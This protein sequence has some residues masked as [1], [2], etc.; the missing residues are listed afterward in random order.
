METNVKILAGI[1][2]TIFVLVIVSAAWP[3]S[4]PYSGGAQNVVFSA[5][6]QSVTPPNSS[7]PTVF[8]L[9]SSNLASATN[10]TF[11]ASYTASS[12]SNITIL[13][14]TNSGST[15]TQFAS[16]SLTSESSLT[17]YISSP[18]SI[19][20]AAQA[21]DVWLVAEVAVSTITITNCAIVV[22]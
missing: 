7:S 8:A 14:S 17:L 15:W 3:A 5:A 6:M 16:Y 21:N 22:S 10:F 11:Y 4:P 1:A 13:Y 20:A 19:P 18:V 2:I 12:P 9:V